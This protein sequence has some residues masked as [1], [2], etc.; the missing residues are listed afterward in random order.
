MS[1]LHSQ[2]PDEITKPMYNNTTFIEAHNNI[3]TL[4][5]MVEMAYGLPYKHEDSTVAINLVDTQLEQDLS[6]LP[7]AR[8]ESRT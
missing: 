6:Q 5:S 8:A 3:E 7:F 2:L 4:V 1:S